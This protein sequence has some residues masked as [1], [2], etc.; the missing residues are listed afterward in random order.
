MRPKPSYRNYTLN[1]QNNTSLV[2]IN[3]VSDHMRLGVALGQVAE[4]I[5]QLIARLHGEHTKG[6]A[7]LVSSSF[8]LQICRK[9][10]NRDL[11]KGNQAA[12]NV[13]GDG[14]NTSG[15]HHSSTDRDEYKPFAVNGEM[16]ESR[17]FP[18]S[19]ASEKDSNFGFLNR[20]ISSF[21]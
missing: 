1:P 9:V 10:V 17:R 20:S 14:V 16:Q 13:S 11:R 2:H 6:T 5:K 15:K 19:S 7:Y 12:S 21:Q 18:Y 3:S 8:N 4:D